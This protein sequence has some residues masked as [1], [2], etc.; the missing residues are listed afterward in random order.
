ML[1]RYFNGYLYGYGYEFFGNSAEKY[2]GTVM[3]IT[4]TVWKKVHNRIQKNSRQYLF[5]CKM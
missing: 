4:V 5:E 2:S 3:G 1:A